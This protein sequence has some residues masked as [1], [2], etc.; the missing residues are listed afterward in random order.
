MLAAQKANR[1]LGCIKRNMASR[2]KEVILPLYS[3][4]VRPYLEYCIQLW[5]PQHKKDMN[6]LEQVQRRATKMIR[7]M[8]HLSYED[9]L[10]EKGR[11]RLFSKACCDRTR[12]NGFKLREGRFRLDLRKKFFTMRVVRHWN[13]LPRKVVEAPS[14]KA[15]K[16]FSGNTNADSVIY[17][18]LQHSI[19]ARFLR[20]VPLDWNPNG[21]IGMRIEV[22]GCTYR[23]YDFVYYSTES[24]CSREVIVPLYSTL[25]RPHVEYCI[26]FWGPQHKTNMDLLEHIQRRAMKVTRGLKYLSCEERLRELGL[27]SLEKKSLWG[28]LIAAFQC[29]KGAYNKDGE[30]L[31]STAC[32]D[33]TPSDYP[34]LVLFHM[35]TNSTARGDLVCI[36]H[37]YIALGERG[38]GTGSQWQLG[39]VPKDWKRANVTHIFNKCKKE[40]LGNYKLVSFISIPGKLKEQII[41]ETISKRVFRIRYLEFS[42]SF[43]AVSYNILIDN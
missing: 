37:D 35:G 33:R 34:P 24:S 2:L 39:E 21:R 1:I 5:S 10:R 38:K 29:L 25:M 32:S 23:V 6:L 27:F 42:K 14:L 31:F 7:G 30:R 17:Y 18:K 28:D 16:A 26:Q 20:F 8:E 3:A 41:L 11:D 19:K 12:S 9:R 4:L 22:Y 13:R 36:K 15:F 40:Y 43:G